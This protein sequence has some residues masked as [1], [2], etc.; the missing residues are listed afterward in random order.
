MKR[1]VACSLVLSLFLLLCLPT[2]ADAIFWRSG[3]KPT[4]TL[5][6][7]TA[8]P[9][10]VLATV[11]DGSGNPAPGQNVA[12]TWQVRGGSPQP[13]PITAT[14]AVGQTTYIVEGNSIA[15]PAITVTATLQNDPS[16]RATVDLRPLFIAL[17]DSYMTW[18]EA[19]AWCQQRGGRL[20]RI[21]GRDS[22]SWEMFDQRVATACN[23][24]HF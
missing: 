18:A 20:P 6:V 13:G 11:K 15:G 4:I 19:R 10:Q 14:N 16:I 12:F 23:A 17:S 1:I 5:I 24:P 9:G 2:T 8:N 21:D 7:D 22:F 3:S